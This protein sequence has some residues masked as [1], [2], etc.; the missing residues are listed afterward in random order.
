MTEKL[1]LTKPSQDGEDKTNAITS[2][3]NTS[4]SVNGKSDRVTTKEIE[5][6]KSAQDEGVK[7]GFYHVRNIYKVRNKS[8]IRFTY[9]FLYCKEHFK[10]SEME[11]EDMERV[12]M[13][14]FHC[15][16]RTSYDYAKCLMEIIVW[17]L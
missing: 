16:R 13:E 6:W 2:L 12:A 4:P 3:F 10:L 5:Y 11:M 9:F 8:L 17:L 7:L 14:L 15:N 1:I